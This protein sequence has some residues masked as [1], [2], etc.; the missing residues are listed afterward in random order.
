M[1]I[2]AN[3]FERALLPVL[4]EE[5][6]GGNPEYANLPRH[7]DCRRTITQITATIFFLGCVNPHL[8]PGQIHATW[9]KRNLGTR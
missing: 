5:G 3:G 9:K 8:L 7:A 2:F 6:N 4:R 1:S